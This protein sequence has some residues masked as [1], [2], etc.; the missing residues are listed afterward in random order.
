MQATDAMKLD[1][2]ISLTL[3]SPERS[4]SLSVRFV[5]HSPRLALFGPSGS[6]KTATLQAIAGLVHPERGHIQVG[7]QRLFDTACGIDVPARERRIGY[8]FQD[9]ALF[10]HLNVEQNIA[11]GVR[12]WGRALTPEQQDLID[13]LMER[14][15]LH[16]MRAAFPKHLSGGQRQRVAIARALAIRPALLLLDE[17]FAA[18]DTG[19][20]AQMREEV[21]QLLT[22]LDTPAVLISHDVQD[23][24]ALAQQVVMLRQG[25]VVSQSDVGASLDQSVNEFYGLAT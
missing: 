17:P 19:L 15:G 13:A 22:G 23:V 16:A 2:D 6:G 24:H 11:Y 7:D 25:A 18:L 14:F 4:F 21:G 3:R 1:I 12:R 20:R 10:P 5:S 8:V 9:Y